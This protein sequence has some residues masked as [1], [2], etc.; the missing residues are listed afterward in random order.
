M[1]DSWVFHE[2]NIYIHTCFPMAQSALL[3]VFRERELV[4]TAAPTA[5][6]DTNRVEALRWYRW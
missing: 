3:S 6:C 5:G 1:N 4:D 2:F